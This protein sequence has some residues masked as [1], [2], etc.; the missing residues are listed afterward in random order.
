MVGSASHHANGSCGG[1]AQPGAT[2]S[3]VFEWTFESRKA[4]ADPFNDVDVDVLFRNRS[5]TLYTGL[6]LQ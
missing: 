6:N 1:G 3:R 5:K 4:F 2:C